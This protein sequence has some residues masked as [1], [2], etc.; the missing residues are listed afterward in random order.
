MSDFEWGVKFDG[1][2]GALKF[3]TEVAARAAAKGLATRTDVRVS[4]VHKVDGQWVE[5]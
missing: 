2:G 3:R 5:A 1:V 4:V